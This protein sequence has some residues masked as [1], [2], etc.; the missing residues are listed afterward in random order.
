[1]PPAASSIARHTARVGDVTPAHLTAGSGDPLV[2]LHGFPQHSHMS[3]PLIAPLAERYTVIAPDLRGMGGLSVGPYACDKRTLAADVRA[4]VQ[5]VLGFGRVRL[6]GYDRGA[7]VAY[8]NAAAHRDEV[9]RVACS[10]FVFPGFGYEA[11]IAPKRGWDDNWQCVAFTVPELCDRFIAGRERELLS[12]YFHAHAARPGAV[13]T[14]D[15]E[16]ARW[17]QPSPAAW[18]RTSGSQLS[19]MQRHGCAGFSVGAAGRDMGRAS[20][21]PWTCGVG[22]RRPVARRRTPRPTT[23]AFG[24]AVW[25]AVRAL[26]RPSTELADA[27]S[28]RVASRETRRRL[29]PRTTCQPVPTLS[30]H[31]TGAPVTTSASSRA[32]TPNS[33]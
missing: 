20:P 17:R 22:G 21:E 27:T 5:G 33:G 6:A 31:P 28:F 32:R 16:H 18:W 8:A 15:P 3:R 29:P 24:A 4:L 25:A 19:T 26:R 12:W 13:A 9:E 14:E 1:M 23:P 30:R 7:G 11:F 10:E 2:L